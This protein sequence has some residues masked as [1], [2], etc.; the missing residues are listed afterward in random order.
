MSHPEM[1]FYSISLNQPGLISNTRAKIDSMLYN[2]YHA[3][4][5]RKKI[6]FRQNADGISYA[7]IGS[8]VNTSL[9][10]ICFTGLAT[11]EVYLTRAECSARMGNKDSAMADLNRLMSKR[12]KN[13]VSFPTFTAND[14]TD[15]LHQV[16]AE[17]RK[18]LVYR[19]LRWTDIRR[20]NEEDSS[21]TLKRIIHGTTY[22]LP[23]NDPRGMI[24]IPWEVITE[25]GIQQNP[26]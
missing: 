7:F 3:D 8:Y 21:I 24:L 17:R 14:A 19:Q 16:L 26:R 9:E 10:Y 22:S 1:I 20:F 2:S 25:S 13:T 18:E 11:D 12:W 4:D 5:L 23:P 6:F 15:A